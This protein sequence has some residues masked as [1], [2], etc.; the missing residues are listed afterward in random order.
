MYYTT[1]DNAPNNCGQPVPFG[2]AQQ[3]FE[4]TVCYWR[5]WISQSVHRGL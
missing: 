5:S 1:G 4:Q 3:L 2:Y